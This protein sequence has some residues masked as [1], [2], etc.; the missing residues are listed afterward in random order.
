[1]NN[2]AILDAFASSPIRAGWSTRIRGQM[3]QFYD[4]EALLLE[5]VTSSDQWHMA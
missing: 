4:R 1:V 3:V 5:Q 2:G